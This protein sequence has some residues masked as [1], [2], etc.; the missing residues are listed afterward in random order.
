M[1][2]SA[3]HLGGGRTRCIRERRNVFCL[4]TDIKRYKIKICID[5][6]SFKPLYCREKSDGER[7]EKRDI[8]YFTSSK[9]TIAQHFWIPTT[10]K[11]S[12]TNFLIPAPT[13]FPRIK[14]YIISSQQLTSC[15][16][17]LPAYLRLSGQ[18]VISYLYYHYPEQY[19]NDLQVMPLV[20]FKKNQRLISQFLM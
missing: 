16:P 1:S 17:D 12:S 6:K 19:Q 15:L 2:I 14:F 9:C 13:A 10:F 7:G 5:R 18:E 8:Y 4:M 20:I 11:N 3:H